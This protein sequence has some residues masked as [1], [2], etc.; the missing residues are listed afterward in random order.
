MVDASPPIRRAR[1][2]DSAAAAAVVQAVYEEYGFTWDELGYHADLRDVEPSYA[3]FFVAQLDGRI[4]GTAGLSGHGLLERLY[5]L[6]S[7]RGAGTGSALP[8]RGRGGG[9]QARPAT[10]GDL[11]R[12]AT[13]GRAPIV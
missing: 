2:A 8:A 4:V 7:A 11:D 1:A 10:A 5:V 13:R 9:A 6:P 12:Q 3:A